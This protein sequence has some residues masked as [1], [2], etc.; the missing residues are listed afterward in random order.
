MRSCCPNV[1]PNKAASFGRIRGQIMRLAVAPAPGKKSAAVA[2]ALEGRGAVP[3]KTEPFRRPTAIPF[4]PGRPR[5]GLVGIVLA[6]AKTSWSNLLGYG[7]QRRNADKSPR[8]RRRTRQQTV[9]KSRRRT[10]SAVSRPLIRRIGRHGM[11]KG[12]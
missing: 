11:K 8:L 5:A 6:F 12:S 4:D 2:G 1:R 9:P 10:N 3:R 7:A